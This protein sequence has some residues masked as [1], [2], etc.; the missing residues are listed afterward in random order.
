MIYYISAPAE[1]FAYRLNQSLK[2]IGT[3]NALLE[4]IL[5]WR[6]DID[7]NLIKAF[8]KDTYKATA[9]EDIED[10]TDG[11]YRDLLIEL[12]NYADED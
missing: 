2:G 5:V 11:N 6:H 9:K 12:L 10:D 8:Y 4:R 3:D 7:M 1:H